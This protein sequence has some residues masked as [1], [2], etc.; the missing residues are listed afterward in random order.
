MSLKITIGRIGK[1]PDYHAPQQGGKQFWTF[2]LADIDSPKSKTDPK[3]HD[4]IWVECILFPYDDKESDRI[5]ELMDV[6]A[7]VYVQGKTKPREY[8]NK[9]GVR[10][11]NDQ[12]NVKEWHVLQYAAKKGEQAK[13]AP[14]KKGQEFNAALQEAFDNAPGPD[15][16]MSF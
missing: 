12:I 8:T 9:E 3:K 15:D 2:S 1:K 11:I 6:G 10:C 14:E 7:L 16:D 13:P 4:T 5:G